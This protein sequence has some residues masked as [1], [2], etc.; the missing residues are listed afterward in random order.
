MKT[1]HIV[2]LIGRVREQANNLIVAELEKRG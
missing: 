2:A 1:D